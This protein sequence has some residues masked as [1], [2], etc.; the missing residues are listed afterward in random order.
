MSSASTRRGL[1]YG[2]VAVIAAAAGIGGAWWRSRGLPGW[3]PG[4]E[5]L[6]DAF[7]SQRFDRPEG[8]ELALTRP[9]R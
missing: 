8:G 3:Q 6:D 1:L 4:G 5:R 9:L 7:W 2:A